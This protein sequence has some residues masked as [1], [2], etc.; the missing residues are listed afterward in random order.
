MRNKMK[1]NVFKVSLDKPCRKCG[2]VMM[3]PVDKG[4]CIPCISKNN[5]KESK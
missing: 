1:P 2:K 5:K 4:I 3:I